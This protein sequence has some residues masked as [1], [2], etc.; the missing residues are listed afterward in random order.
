VSHE[1]DVI[2][3]QAPHEIHNSAT[4]DINAETRTRPLTLDLDETLLELDPEEEAFFKSETGIQDTEEL[5]RHIVEVQED[6]YKVSRCPCP[7]QTKSTRDSN[8]V[9]RGQVY[10]YPCIRG[11]RFTNLRITRRPTYPHVL[12]LGKD[13]PDAIFLDIGCCRKNQLVLGVCLDDLTDNFAPGCVVGAEV[14]KVIHDGWPM[15]HAIATDLRAGMV[16]GRCL[17]S[18]S[19]NNILLSQQGSGI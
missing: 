6:A 1:L 7:D 17:H 10:P 15:S 16:P 8:I 3:N 13:R 5:R 2:S 12:E 18:S 19:K 9:L 14:R 4:M 11:F